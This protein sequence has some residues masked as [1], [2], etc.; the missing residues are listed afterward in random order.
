M[1]DTARVYTMPKCDFH[2]KAHDAEFDFRT[3][4]GFWG[5]GCQQAFEEFGV[6]LGTGR[7]QRL[8]LRNAD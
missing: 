8:E 5:N 4:R 7:G 2:G 3:R 1:S 6:G